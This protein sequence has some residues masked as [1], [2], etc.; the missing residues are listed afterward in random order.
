MKGFNLYPYATVDDVKAAVDTGAKL[1]RYQCFTEPALNELP[2][3][4]W[5]RFLDG[6]CQAVERFVPV[7]GDARI[8]IDLHRPPGGTGGKRM[9]VFTS[10]EYRGALYWVWQ[11]VV[12][13]FKDTPQVLGY[14]ILNEPPGSGKDVRNLMQDCVNVIREIDT[15]KIIAVTTSGGQVTEADSIGNFGVTGLWYELHMYEPMSF[16]HQGIGTRKRNVKAPTK[17]KIERELKGAIKIQ[18]SGRQVF[19]GEFSASIYAPEY[20]RL[21]YIRNCIELFNK[22]GFHWCFHIWRENGSP[23]WSA[24]A[25]PVGELLRSAMR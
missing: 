5:A 2:L 21:T 24:E 8:V 19:I 1:L 16:T 12:N 9:K 10:N 20:E 4:E 6:F 23:V 14:G 13:R 7:V 18:N 3:S 17:Q 25:E 22:Y 15:K 11:T